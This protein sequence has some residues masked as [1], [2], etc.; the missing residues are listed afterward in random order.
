MKDL[1]FKDIAENIEM[2]RHTE[3]F[4]GGLRMLESNEDNIKILDYQISNIELV[5]QTFQLR[6]DSTIKR[7]RENNVNNV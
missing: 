5:M 7:E 4:L 3:S 1:T 2:L 6:I